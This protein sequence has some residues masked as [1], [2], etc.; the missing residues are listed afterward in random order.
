MMHV[1]AGA[2]V[3]ISKRCVLKLAGACEETWYRIM[4][5]NV[6]DKNHNPT[7]SDGLC[8]FDSPPITPGG[9]Q[10]PIRDSHQRKQICRID[11]GEMESGLT[12]GAFGFLILTNRASDRLVRPRH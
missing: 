4:D 6:C 10:C 3:F 12:A 5:A 9:D 8:R 11:Q 2:K 1:A 7:I